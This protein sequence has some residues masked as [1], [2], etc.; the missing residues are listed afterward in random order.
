MSEHQLPLSR[1]RWDRPHALAVRHP[2]NWLRSYW[3][4]RHSGLLPQYPGEIDQVFCDNLDTFLWGVAENF[5]GF[6]SDLFLNRYSGSEIDPTGSDKHMI[7]RTESLATDFLRLI[8]RQLGVRDPVT[9]ADVLSFPYQNASG[10]SRL[11][12]GRDTIRALC[13][14]E[15]ELIRRYY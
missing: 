6:V 15:S 5:S 10:S 11:V 2:A 7:L 1:E 4:S 14:S 9:A 13:D 3:L 8:R 12:V